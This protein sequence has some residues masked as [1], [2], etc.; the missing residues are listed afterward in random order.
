M[1]G[2]VRSI[3]RSTCASPSTSRRASMPRACV[4]ALVV[5]SL[6]SPPRSVQGPD[7][8]ACR[9]PGARRPGERRFEP[10]AECLAGALTSAQLVR[11]CVASCAQ[12]RDERP[13]IGEPD[14]LCERERDLLGEDERAVGLE[15]LRASASGRPR[16]LRA[17]PRIAAAAPP[18]WR[19]ASVSAL[20]SA[21][22]SPAARWCSWTSEPASMPTQPRRR[23]ARTRRQA[24]T[25]P[26]SASAASSRSRHPPP[27]PPRQ[28]P[29]GR[30]ARR[31]A[32]SSR[33]RLR[34]AAS[35]P[36]SSATRTR[37]MCHGSV[38][39]AQLELPGVSRQRAPARPRRMH[40]ACRRRPRAGR[41]DAR[42]A[43]TRAS[44]AHRA[45]R[46]A[47][48][49]PRGRT[50]SAR[51]AAAACARPSRFPGAHP[52]A[53]RTPPPHPRRRRAR[54]GVAREATSIAALSRMSW[55]V[56]PRCTQSA[57]GGPTRSRNART[58]GST[59]FPAARPCS[60]IAS[61]S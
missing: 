57:E 17:P 24:P 11:E 47:T 61:T 21:C 35:A 20:H 16:G 34:D 39:S 42:V 50:S 38:G 3:A 6:T 59:G 2:V 44:R 30:A 36:P 10:V 51:P 56:A 31:H 7:R 13:R 48:P 4:S 53:A 60:R 12:L 32:R 8:S 18:A 22:H 27:P 43:R 41:R 45:D 52:P 15:V 19:S 14:P 1:N 5:S 49:P 23:R 54:S 9:R 58:S 40:R 26:G 37:F 55:L 25:R 28:P 29:S 33:T 46:R